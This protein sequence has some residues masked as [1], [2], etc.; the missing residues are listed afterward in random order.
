MATPAPS[1]DTSSSVGKVFAKASKEWTIPP[2]PRPGRKAAETAP[3]TGKSAQNREAQRAFRER[4]QDYV[5]ELEQRCRD[6]EQQEVQKN[7]S[8]QT[9]SLALKAENQAL[10]SDNDR[11]KALVAQLGGDPTVTPGSSGSGSSTRGGG[12]GAGGRK[13]K[14][15]K[16]EELEDG[17]GSFAGDNGSRGGS[18]SRSGSVVGEGSSTGEVGGRGKSSPSSAYQQQEQARRP[19]SSSATPTSS[20]FPTT[21]YYPPSTTVLAGPSTSISPPTASPHDHSSHSQAHPH[22]HPRPPTPSASTSNPSSFS[23]ASSF[24]PSCGFCTTNDTPCICRM[25]AE[26]RDLHAGFSGLLNSSDVSPKPAPAFGVDYPASHLSSSTGGGAVSLPS[27]YLRRRN[28]GT[29]HQAPA[30]IWAYTSLSS[31]STANSS[32]SANSYTSLARSTNTNPSTNPSSPSSSSLVAPIFNPSFGFDA[33]TNRTVVAAS[34]SDPNSLPSCTGNPQDCPACADDPFGKAFCETLEGAEAEDG[35]EGGETTEGGGCS[36]GSGVP[37]GNCSETAK[38]KAAGGDGPIVELSC[39]GV[40]EA[41]GSGSSTSSCVDSTSGGGG[42]GDESG[43]NKKLLLGG[44]S[45]ARSRSSMS[46]SSFAGSEEPEGGDPHT[47][48]SLMVPTSTAWR[49]F[50][51]HPNTTF[52]DLSLLAEVVSRRIPACALS[53]NPHG[54]SSLPPPNNNF[55]SA[56]SPF[57]APSPSSSFVKLEEEDVSMGNFFGSGSVPPASRKRRRAEVEVEGVRE[58]LRILDARGKRGPGG[59][60]LLTATGIVSV[61]PGVVEVAAGRTGR[62][63]S[64]LRGTLDEFG[65]EEEEVTEEQTGRDRQGDVKMMVMRA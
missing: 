7:I 48:G 12:A 57:A 62:R 15:V 35:E 23:Y 55:A 29:S 37:C 9:I 27:A 28:S 3:K 56:S 44:G 10:K 41:C 18:A 54:S 63:T 13:R 47:N 45:S 33:S 19:S 5:A 46:T 42:A 39:C 20:N 40:P 59:E 43:S 34:S 58:A 4:K 53:P 60:V 11:L 61:A 36:S 64:D 32:S 8:L 65:V 30:A 51:S 52:A 17:S 49:Q 1:R 14:K 6:Y 24:V 2:R 22:P 50:K 21:N 38:S 26:S 16:V 25:A 31:S